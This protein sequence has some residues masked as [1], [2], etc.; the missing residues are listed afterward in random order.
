MNNKLK[1]KLIYD[2]KEYFFSNNYRLYN[3]VGSIL[4]LDVTVT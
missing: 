3:D 4:L 2:K 1:K